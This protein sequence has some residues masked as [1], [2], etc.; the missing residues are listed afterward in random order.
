MDAKRD[1]E[2][3][4]AESEDTRDTPLP[5]ATGGE[6]RGRSVVQSVRLPAEDL[7]EIERLARAADIP[8]SALIRG[9]VLSGLAAERGTSLRDAIERVAGEAERLRRLATSTDVA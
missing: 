8:V 2:I 7:A 3:V 5:R 9:W 6:R 4:Q 1:V